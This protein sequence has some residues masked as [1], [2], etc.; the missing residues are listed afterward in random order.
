MC[1]LAGVWTTGGDQELALREQ[2]CRMAGT[3]AH[4]GPDDSG[5]WI[6]PQA[7]LAFGFRRLAIV[8]LSE[9]GHQPMMSADGRY[10]IVFNGEIYN[11]RELRA[12]LEALGFVFR[13]RSDTEVILGAASAWGW[14]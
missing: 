9:G 8:D 10:V 13:S 4:R 1:G 12:E 7:G 3:L 11:F 5:H 2:V 6:D 14:S